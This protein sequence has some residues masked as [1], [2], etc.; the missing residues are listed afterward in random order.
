MVLA[1]F[2]MMVPHIMPEL[3]VAQR[4]RSQNVKTPIV[5]SNVLVRNWR[6]WAHSSCS[7][8]DAPMSFHHGRP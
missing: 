2:H 7:A 5:Y 3:P 8:I 4:E 1:C 6:A